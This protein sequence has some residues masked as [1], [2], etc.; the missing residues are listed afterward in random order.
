MNDP[1]AG[2]TI[3][4]LGFGNQGEAQALNLRDAG[5]TVVVG[6]R[7]GG[8]GDARARAHGFEALPLAEAARRADV[9]AVLL[10][11]ELTPTLWPGILPA[12]RPGA[13][14]VFAHGFNLLYAEL[15]FPPDADVVLVSPT[16][17]GRVL[18]EVVARGGG[19]PAYLAVHRDA[20]GKAWGLAERYA[21]A[22][23]CG[24]AR[25]W[26]TTVREE[27]EV[28]LF[29]EQAVLCGGMNALVTTAFEVLVAKGY[30]PEIAYLECVH[31]LKYLADLLHER[32]VAGMRRGISGTALFG[33]LTRG[34]RVVGEA[35]RA[36]MAAL[37]EEIRSGSFAR[38][39]G[40]EVAHGRAR[41]D[42]E[43][44]RGAGHPIEEARRRAL[45]A[46]AGPVEPPGESRKAL[47]KN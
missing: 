21:A 16:G 30:S 37:L 20:S 18:R 9:C 34:P 42:A 29:G 3:A 47:S 43:V 4:V 19:L 40:D 2:V 24:R 31:Q 10:P 41:L 39:W 35:S 14:L 13:G 23:G 11:D 27:T 17:P 6:A 36:A 38:E 7:A 15:A 12:L 45:A 5:V 28:D 26:R 22:L 44:A 33:D 8:G 32:G 1:L 46:G 25:L